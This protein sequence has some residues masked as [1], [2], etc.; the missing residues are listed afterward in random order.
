MD[1]SEIYR[2]VGVKVSKQPHITTQQYR[3]VVSIA[4]NSN[5]I[6]QVCVKAIRTYIL[7]KQVNQLTKGIAS[8]R[9]FS[10]K[11]EIEKQEKD[12]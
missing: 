2:K 6:K 4:I 7:E 8:Y 3:K 1:A 10:K 11:T 12:H 9:D 5:E